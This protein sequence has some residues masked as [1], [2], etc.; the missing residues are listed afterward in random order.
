MYVT[1]M[2]TDQIPLELPPLLN[3]ELPM[4]PH[5]VNG[6]GSQ[7]VILV[8][9]NPGETFTIRA[10]DGSLQCIQGPAEVPMMSPNGSIPPIHVPPGYIS[11]V[12][13]DN[14]GVRRVVVTPQSP[15][16]FPPSYPS[17]ISPTHHLPPYITHH[18]HLIPHSHA[19]YYPPVTGPGD[20]PPQFFQHHLPP[21]IYGEQEFIPLYGM[22]SYITREDQYS[23]HDRLHKKLK[24]DRQN[25][26][27]SPPSTI[28]KN[29]MSSCATIYNGYGKGPCVA[30]VGG[31][32]GTGIKKSERRARSSPRMNE[33]DIQD[34]DSETKRVQDMLSGMGRP[35]VSNVQARAALLTWAP[36]TGLTNGDKQTNGLPYTCNYEVASSD[37]GKDGKYKIIYSGEDLECSLTDLQPTT[38]YHIRVSTIYNSVKGSYSEPVSFTTQS[39]APDTPSPPKLSHRTKSTL[40]IQWKAP[41]DNGSKITSY[42]LEWDEGKRNNRFRECYFGNQ[43]HYKLTKLLPAIGYTFRLAACNDI[44]TS[45]FSQEV[46]CYTAGNVPQPPA[47]PRLVRAGVTWVTLQW[48]RPD[49]SSA[50]EHITYMLEME[51]ES[52]TGGFESMYTGE[53]V[54]S[55]VKSLTRSTQY[56]FR[57]IASNTEG[58]SSP[59]EV[60]VCITNPDQPGPPST[61]YVIGPPLSHSLHLKWDPPEDN[62]GSE[63]LKYLL[64]ISEGSSEGSQWEVVYSG[65]LNETVCQQLKPGTLYRFRACCISTGGH[66]QCSE[67]LSV[68]TQCVA[69]GQC[70][71]PRLVGKPKHKEFQM[72]WGPPSDGNSMVTQYTLE[73]S[74][75]ELAPSEV[76]CGPDLECTVSSLLP[77]T[78]YQ[79]RVRAAN[80]AG[81]GPYSEAIDLTTA[82]GPPVQCKSPALSCLS[83]TS[84]HVSWESPENYGDDISEYRLE[85]GETEESMDLVYCGMETAFE[86]NELKPA[87]H[88]CC[89]LQATN[90]AGCGPY[91]S[92]ITHTTPASVPDAIST[93]FVLEDQHLDH[94]LTSTSSCLAVKWTEP[95]SNGSEILSYSIDLGESQL[96]VDNVTAYIIRDLL[97]G[98]SYRIRVRAVN[99]I[100]AGPFSQAVKA[101]T[102]PLPPAPPRLECAA[103]GPQSLKLKWGD[104][105]I[106]K[107][108]PT[109]VETV[110]ILQME[111]RSGKF[112]PIYRGPSH[113]Y[114]VQR[115][116]ESTCYSFR[117]QAV[118]EAGEGPFS[119]VHVFNTTK[120]LPP[121]LK[122]P[123]VTQL[124][125]TACEVTWEGLPPMR[126]DPMS[127]ILQVTLGRELDYKQVYKGEDTTFQISGLQTNTD[128]RFRVCACRR[129]QD[130]SQELTG[131]FSPSAIFTLRRKESPPTS[132]LRTAELAKMRSVMPSDEQFAALIL[133]GF[134]SLSIFIAFVLQYFI[135]K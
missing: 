119:T 54:T 4:M 77:G 115:L 97:P 20:L 131:P 129:C 9:V 130:M 57:L 6:D 92:V 117:I 127:Y 33:Q 75:G 70:Q 38:D 58:S 103:S 60:L 3:G 104:S 101:K 23:K 13:E 85:W 91:S 69:P 121:A 105:S 28:Y 21:T 96:T 65:S 80:E 71:P 109:D 63:I 22:S 86:I 74:Q 84:V 95:C 48:N 7:Q 113:T 16:C 110:Y 53:E 45:G 118:T 106:T 81:Y 82:T 17:A 27:N 126:G 25:R 79:F 46:V 107:V 2:M 14:T 123:R 56:K 52:S 43:R 94:C 26:L 90:Q 24:I 78:T 1:M 76:Y 72:Q 116:M 47:A 98:T 35:Q 62:G 102:R 39:C 50:E 41:V 134:A 55:T 10:E 66:S 89:R 68:R 36:P 128:Y 42:L 29:H 49:G 83:T 40:T 32:G 12:I 51:E 34:F 18:P 88:Y 59:S 124:E 73:M 122:A 37:K 61:P 132:E 99:G 67:S 93:L 112:I 8:Q 100:G 87:T 31:G 11:Q 19:A 133:V 125:G 114:K 44:G 111:E 5:L 135:M 64:E 108:L 120:L 15:E 30:G